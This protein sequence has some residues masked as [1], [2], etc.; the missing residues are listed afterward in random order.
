[1][2]SIRSAS[3]FY[4]F[5]FYISL[6]DLSS[7]MLKLWCLKKG[8]LLQTSQFE[9]WLTIRKNRF[10]KKFDRGPFHFAVNLCAVLFSKLHNHCARQVLRE[11]TYGW[12]CYSESAQGIPCIKHIARKRTL[13]TLINFLAYT[14]DY[15]QD[16]HISSTNIAEIN[17]CIV[18][19]SM[20]V[21]QLS[22]FTL[23]H[24]HSI[25]NRILH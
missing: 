24:T 13:T 5:V 15:A 3:L 23:I 19:S 22:A 6:D 17:A 1:M 16:S 4:V 12:S 14:F 21:Q 10:A 25:V 2:S 18:K 20:L 9:H 11:L 7:N 8:P